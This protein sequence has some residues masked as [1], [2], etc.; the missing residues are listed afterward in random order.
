M[1]RLEDNDPTL[2]VSDGKGQRLLAEA[3]GPIGLQACR[4]EI[5]DGS[6]FGLDGPVE[7][8]AGTPWWR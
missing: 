6:V 8:E 3:D 4:I 1:Q 2:E 7:F 5:E